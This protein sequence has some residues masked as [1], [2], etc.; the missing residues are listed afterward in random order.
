MPC[1]QTPWQHTQGLSGTQWS[2]DLF[3]K[4]SQKDDPP[5]CSPTSPIPGLNQT[6][7]SQ[8]PSHENNSTL[9]PEPEVAPMQ[10]T[11]HPFCK[12]QFFTFSCY[13]PSLTTPLTIS[14]LSFHVPLNNHH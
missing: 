4:P 13:Q 6:S 7:D 9:G 2:E 14:T 1:E 8:L 12:Y 3:G 11:E 5:I 10:S